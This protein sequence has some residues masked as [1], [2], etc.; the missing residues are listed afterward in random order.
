M[1]ANYG[2]IIVSRKRHKHVSGVPLTMGTLARVGFILLLPAGPLGTR[3]LFLPLAMAADPMIWY[4]LGYF[5]IHG[6]P[7]R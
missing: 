5:L 6:V 7:G 4:A 3:L 1:T 2:A